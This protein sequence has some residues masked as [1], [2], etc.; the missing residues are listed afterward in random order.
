MKVQRMSWKS[1][2][3]FSRGHDPV[4]KLAPWLWTGRTKEV[5]TSRKEDDPVGH[6]R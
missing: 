6:E 3:I 2:E 4:S 1:A 5:R